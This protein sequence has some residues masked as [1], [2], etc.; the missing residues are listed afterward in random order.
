MKFILRLQ[1]TEYSSKFC[2]EQSGHTHFQRKYEYREISLEIEDGTKNRNGRF[3]KVFV[4][5]SKF[6]EGIME[7]ECASV[8]QREILTQDHVS[9]KKIGHGGES[10]ENLSLTT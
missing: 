6:S 4:G 9:T 3:Q 5:F 8:V 1:W 2:E 7:N 10:Y